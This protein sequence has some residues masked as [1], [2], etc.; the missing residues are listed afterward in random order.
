MED[1]DSIIK[2]HLLDKKDDTS[3]LDDI[4][5]NS[6]NASKLIVSKIRE[7]HYE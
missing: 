1:I 4:C 5:L 3:N 7:T 2:N 6:F